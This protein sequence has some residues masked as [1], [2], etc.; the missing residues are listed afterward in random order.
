[1]ARVNSNI[2]KRCMIAVAVLLIGG[3]G[4]DIYRL[5]Y[6]QIFNSEKYKVH[7]ESDQLSD[8]QIAADRGVIYDC[9]MET[10]AESAS[11]WLVYVNP[12]KIADG[13]QKSTIAKGLSDI[14]KDEN[15]TEEVIAEKISN[16][17]YG[18]VKIKGKIEYE[19]KSAVQSFINDNNLYGIVS[20]DPDT[21]RYYPYGNF[22]SSVIGMTNIDGDGR[23][24]VEY[25]YNDTLTGVPGRIITA[26]DGHSNLMSSNYETKF[27]A[28]QGTSLVLTIDK[29]IQH[30]LEKGLSQAVTDNEAT[31]A[32]GIVMN[33]NTGAVLAMA[34]MPD[35]D[36]N[37]PSVI[38]DEE[39]LKELSKI[40][41]DEKRAQE[42]NNKV[43]LMWRNKVISDTYEPG[44]VFKI[45]TA[46]AALEEGVAT[47]DMTYTCGGSIQVADNLIHCH[48]LAG[49]GTQ[50]LEQGLVNSCNPFFITLGQ[51]LGT[52]R[53]YK[54]FEAFGFTNKTGIDLPEEAKPVGGVTYH[55][56]EDMGISQLSS[57][58]FGQ[59]FQVSP[60]QMIT[61]VSAIANGGNLMEPY[62]VAKQ[63][64]QE[65][66]TV[67]EK[68][69]TVKRQV[70]SKS[71]ANTVISMMESVVNGGT[72][73]N[74]YIP[75]YR[76]AGKTGTSEKLTVDGEYI[77]SFVGCAPADDPQIAVLI[78]ID[79]P[80]GALHG[81]GAIAAP[82]AGSIIEQSLKYMNVEPVYTDEELSKMNA[83]TPD[84]TGMTVSAAVSTLENKE[85]TARVVGDGE[86]V[87]S[88][89]PVKDQGIQLGGVVILYTDSENKDTSSTVPD[90]IGLSISEANKKA[91]NSGYNIKISGST[92][93]SEVVSYRQSIEP[94]TKAELGTTITVYFKT[95]SGVQDD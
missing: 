62:V 94:G 16:S 81:G 79:E 26:I 12:S 10:L 23:T 92:V 70:V 30:Y 56:K 21:K 22:A 20:I 3:F 58:S 45:F 7:A 46:A 63:I 41:D 2:K 61:A 72:G 68:T 93:S 47:K 74:A 40:E 65:G 53:F 76:V 14:L 52:E 78:I 60:I 28:K 36:L 55:T 6:Y 18:Y 57:S 54:Y 13:A 84:V 19:T 38:T 44:S 33:V 17:N 24:G 9:N 29:N 42:Y 83:S 27:E 32:Y 1:M 75:G 43:Y 89:Y 37:N 82:V 48:N 4:L 67:Y 91:V 95:T 11:A 35:Y 25:K 69:P 59:T 50:T 34:T 85:F 66:N 51:K 49:H 15:L 71:T 90:L 64:D 5:A 77:A 73:K 31:S 80:H 87:I 86:R 88:Q 8:T 39:T